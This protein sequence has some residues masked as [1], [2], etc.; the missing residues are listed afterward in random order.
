M[1]SVCDRESKAEGWF[2]L[3]LVKRLQGDDEDW[4]QGHHLTSDV[5]LDIGKMVFEC[6][7][8]GSRHFINE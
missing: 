3:M 8:C 6:I 5:N 7:H 4:F 1:A 2:E